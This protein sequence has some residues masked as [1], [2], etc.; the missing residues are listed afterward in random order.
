[1][2]AASAFA[3]E[4]ATSI[5]KSVPAPRQA[6][7]F[8]V[9]TSYT[10]GFSV[11]ETGKP[12]GNIAGPG[13]SVGG[14]LGYRANPAWSVGLTGSYD[15]FSPDNRITTK[16]NIHGMTA[17]VEGTVHLAP[18][19]RV[20]PVATVGGGYRAFMVGEG[21]GPTRVV[22]GIQLAK[23]TFGLDIRAAQ[24]FAIG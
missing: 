18:F 2:A 12:I 3:Q 14:K 8:G 1:T 11:F 10:Q 7:E 22:H 23:V 5:G 17:G 13:L 19:S 16:T 20:D 15:M 9:D 24:S 4:T 6:L 21:R